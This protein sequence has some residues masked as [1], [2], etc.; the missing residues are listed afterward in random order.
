MLDLVDELEASR[1]RTLKMPT[2]LM[3]NTKYYNA[4]VLE[5][6]K[7]LTNHESMEFVLSKL[8]T[9]E[10]KMDLLFRGSLDGFEASR[11][12]E[13]CNKQGPTLVVVLSER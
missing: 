13:K 4:E 11:F 2:M 3:E 10:F 12:H 6:S 8:F 5:S 9:S 1:K 7:V